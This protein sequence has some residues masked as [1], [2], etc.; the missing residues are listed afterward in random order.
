M[1]LRACRRTLA[2]MAVAACSPMTPAIA[3]APQDSGMVAEIPLI[4]GWFEGQPV[5]YITTDVS[6]P[7]AARQAG[8]NYVPKLAN[9]LPAEPKTPGQRVATDRIYGFTNFKQGSVLPSRPM[10]IGAS[11]TDQNYSPLWQV[12]KVS[13]LAGKTP[14]V[15]R[16]EEEVLQAQ[17]QGEVTISATG[18]VANCPVVSSTP[19]GPLPHVRLK[20]LK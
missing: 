20:N 16:S 13:W 8:A 17:E 19:G 14:R 15:L 6:D 9:A 10:P 18:I 11:N 7:D 4:A 5:Y 2:C 3:A 12:H 1:S